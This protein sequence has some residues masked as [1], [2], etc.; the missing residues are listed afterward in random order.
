M[1]ASRPLRMASPSRFSS[2]EQCHSRAE[3]GAPTGAIARNGLISFG[4]PIRP[5]NHVPEQRNLGRYPLRGPHHVP[6]ATLY[7]HS[8]SNRRDC[9]CGQR[10]HLHGRER[11]HDPVAALRRA[12]PDHAGGGK[13]RQTQPA[14]LRCL[15]AEFPL[16]ARGNAIVRTTRRSGLRHLYPEREWRARATHWKPHQPGPDPGSRYQA[17]RRTRIQSG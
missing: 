5:N 12:Q 10:D 13:E 11:G 7:G 16:L 3:S 14:D 4:L 1:L 6:G 17:P 15:G 9:D 8:G 2:L